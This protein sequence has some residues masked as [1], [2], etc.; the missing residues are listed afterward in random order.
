MKNWIKII[1]TMNYLVIIGR[2]C[3]IDP[4][5]LLIYKTTEADI[6]FERTGTHADLFE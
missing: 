2:E 3:H 6:I 4:D 1:K 5:W